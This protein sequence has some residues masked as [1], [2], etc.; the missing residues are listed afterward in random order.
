MALLLFYILLALGISFLC[1][2][3]EAVLLSI[4]PSFVVKMQQKENALG[5]RL[6][7]FKE[8][9]DK[10][11]AAILSLNTIAHTVGA[12]GAGAQAAH[13]FGSTY[14]GIISAILTFL[15]LVVSEIIPKTIGAVYWRQLTKVVLKLL[16]PTIWTMFP[17]V[18]LAEWLTRIL[19]SGK[20]KALIQRDEFLAL[21]ELGIREGILDENEFRILKNLFRFREIH[22]KDI[23]TPRTVVFALS[24]K[25]NI[26][27][28]LSDLKSLRFTRIPIFKNKLDEITGYVLKSDILMF[29]VQEKNNI[30]LSDIKRPVLVV[31]EHLPL[32]DIFEQL[33]VKRMQLAVVYDQYG[34]L[35]GLV[36]LEDIT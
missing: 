14:V 29:A 11:L 17:L 16:V 30:S 12:A 27:K 25:Q 3:M 10:P 7:E 4:T 34:S 32:N 23:M 1:S 9:I 20:R 19:T 6:Q 22:V 26:S 13:I 21:T 28:V 15:I 18:K 33:L 35:V 31:Q 5:K 24:E 36:T 2:I 8:N